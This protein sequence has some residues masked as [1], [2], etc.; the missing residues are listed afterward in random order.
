MKKLAILAGAG[1]LAAALVAPVGPAAA[2]GPECDH[3]NHCYGLIFYRTGD[4]DAVGVDLWTDCLHLD[5]PIGD[6]ATH[7]MWMSTETATTSRWIEGGYIRGGPIAGGD[8]ETWFRWFWGE[9]DGSVYYSHFV[10]WAT[11]NQW[12]NISFYHQSSTNT[13]KV[14][15]GG[16]IVGTTVQQADW[17][18]RVEVGAETTEP[19]VYSH[20]KSRNL[21][22][23]APIGWTWATPHSTGATTGVYSVSGSGT[24]MEQTSLQNM[25]SPAPLAAKEA[26]PSAPSTADVKKTALAVAGQYGETSPTGLEMVATTRKAAQR[27]VGAGDKMASDQKTYLVQMKGSFVGRAPKGAKL[28][29]GSAMTVTVDAETGAVTDLSIGGGRQDLAKLGTVKAL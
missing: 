5:T 19:Q 18:K 16:T 7:E 6:F 20:G 10:Q 22:W 9:Y 15:I 23:H 13:W 2:D 17:G 24:S 1:M 25:C 3:Y 29:R 4:I 8:P 14:Y 27:A 12:K 26:A 11:V 28:P 21:Q